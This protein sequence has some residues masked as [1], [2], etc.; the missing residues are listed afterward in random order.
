MLFRSD[1]IEH[2]AIIDNYEFFENAL[3]HGEKVNFAIQLYM[4]F[5][6]YSSSQNMF[7]IFDEPDLSLHPEWQKKYI[8]ELINIVSRFL[9]INQNTF[10][11]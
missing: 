10:L 1:S 6:I 8:N 9:L 3:S 5:N 11:H 2:I 4:N 7:Y